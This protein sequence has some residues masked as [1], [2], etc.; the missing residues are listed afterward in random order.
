MLER[1]LKLHDLFANRLRG[2]GQVFVSPRLLRRRVRVHRL[3]LAL[4]HLRVVRECL[5][6]SLGIENSVRHG[7]LFVGGVHGDDSGLAR[8]GVHRL[9][10]IQD[11]E[12][13]LRRV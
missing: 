1:R 11:T 9:E 13:L 3:N 12:E 6:L 10:P 5:D 4:K 2:L 7:P 8:H